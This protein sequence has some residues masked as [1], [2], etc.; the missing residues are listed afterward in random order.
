MLQGGLTSRSTV[1]C[2]CGG[3]GINLESP[4]LEIPE[5]P[6]RSNPSPS[7]QGGK[8]NL[9]P[10]TTKQSTPGCMPPFPKHKLHIDCSKEGKHVLFGENAGRIFPDEKL[11]CPVF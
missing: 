7:L 11:R 5:T 8:W 3:I 2:G 1:E 9:Q 4:A 6:C 10:G